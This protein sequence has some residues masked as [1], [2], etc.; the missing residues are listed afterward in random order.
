M[1]TSN[2]ISLKLNSYQFNIDSSGNLNLISNTSSQWI[3][4]GSNIYYNTGNVGIATTD[5]K[6]L[7]HVTG[8]L[9]VHNGVGAAPT[10]GLYGS[11]GTRLILWPGAPDNTPY[12]FGTAGGTLWYSVPTGANH[13]FY[14]GTTERLRINDAG[15]ILSCGNIDC[16]G[17]ISI[18]GSNAFYFISDVVD[19]GNRTNTYI[20]F[21]LAGSNNDL[22]HLRQIGG[23]NTCKLAFDFTMMEMMPVFV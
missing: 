9:L 1:N 19:A 13:I 5:P 10:N 6:A 20:N 23:N 14:V 12:S 3:R 21:K 8:R 15:N 16:G 18:N 4:S 7:L 22:C 11:D 2:T 17:G